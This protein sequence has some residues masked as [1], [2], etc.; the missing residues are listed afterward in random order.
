MKYLLLLLS[1]LMMPLPGHGGNSSSQK[2]KISKRSYVTRPKPILT[3]AF[4]GEKAK[5]LAKRRAGL[6]SDL[7]E[8]LTT[9]RDRKTKAELELRLANLYVEE[10]K[11]QAGT[12][13]A[14]KAYLSKA[15]GLLSGIITEYPS[16][17]RLDEAQFQLAQA[18]IEFG[19][20]EKA[21]SLF[22]A[23]VTRNPSSPFAQE[24]FLQLADD[25]FSKNKFDLAIKYFKSL[26]SRETS[27]LAAYAHYKLA[28]ANY[29]LGLITPSIIHFKSVINED[30][31][32]TPSTHSIAL[33]KEAV[34]DLCLPLGEA[35]QY[36][37]GLEFYQ[38]QGEA[39]FKTGVECL[40][41]VASEKGDFEA[42]INLYTQL[43][44]TD[45]QSASNPKYSLAISE[46]YRKTNQPK[47]LQSFLTKTIDFYLG[48]SSWNEIHSHSPS[49]INETKSSFEE[50]VRKTAIDTHAVA[51]KTK[52]NELYSEA[53]LFYELYIKYFGLTSQAA[54]MQFHL[55]E[56]LFK[57]NRY[58]E[59]A[60]AYHQAF[61]KAL[62]DS[63]VKRTALEYAILSRLQELN[64][65]RKDSGLL[66]ISPANHSKHKANQ[67][68]ERTSSFTD[69]E[70][71]FIA[72]CELFL[73]QYPNDPK[74]P[75]ILFKAAYLKYLQS[76]HKSAY[77]DFWLLVQKHPKDKTALYG[78]S[79]LLDIL[80]QRQDLAGLIKASQR[81]LATRELSDPSFRKEVSDVLRKAEL[82]NISTLEKQ[83]KFDEAAEAYQ[84]FATHYG[85]QDPQLHESALFNASI[86]YSKGKKWDSALRAQERFLKLFPQ[87]KLRS[88]LILQVAKSYEAQA[89]FGQAA[90][91]FLT[92][93]NENP[94]H[95][96]SQEALRLA[97]LYFWGAGQNEKAERSFL[98]HL[99]SF[100]QSF[101]TTEKDLLDFYSHEGKK[102]ELRRYLMNARSKKG[103]TPNRYLDYT[104]QLINL[105]DGS[106]AEEPLWKQAEQVVSQSEKSLLKTL[107]GSQILGKTLLYQADRLNKQYQALSLQVSQAQLEKT[108][109]K[110]LALTKELER[111]YSQIAALGGDVGL[112]ALYHTSKTYHQLAQ[113]IQ[114]A[115][116]PTDLTSEQLDI[117]R[118]ELKKQMI[119][120]FREKALA[121]ST[122]CTDKAEE[123]SLISPWMAR[124]FDLSSQMA[125][126]RF[127]NLPTFSLSPFY[128]ANLNS[129]FE[130]EGSEFS[131]YFSPLL[132]SERHRERAFFFSDLTTKKIS[133]QPLLSERDKIF[134]KQLRMNPKTPTDYFKYLSTLRLFNPEEAITET[135]KYL[136]KDQ[137]DPAFHNILALAYL[138]T[139]QLEKAKITWLS[140]LARGFS[141]PALFNNL[142]V[143]E[144]IR[145]N[146]ED[147]LA[148]WKKAELEN[149]PES[150]INQG[151]VALIHRNGSLAKNLFEKAQELRSD[152]LAEIGKR[153]AH[154]Q[155]NPNDDSKASF[156]QL[157]SKYRGNPLFEAQQASL[158]S[159]VRIIASESNALPE[160]E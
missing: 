49:L 57:Q 17:E 55:A 97:G 90:N 160:L 152:S 75:E 145:G 142:G 16:F 122:Q 33:K 46:I 78:G 124:C 135:K 84:N 98:R 101:E 87:S 118:S 79:L 1:C 125:P 6:I 2:I 15:K 19:D 37:S 32:S 72:L 29:N 80:N 102:E 39:S 120:P 5:L 56:I 9:S 140:L 65:T 81:L 127:N 8:A 88:E 36:E 3:D 43:L 141:D 54:Q 42:A 44:K 146:E 123:L 31:D 138:E 12:G 143:L 92:F 4:Q 96:Q 116:I 77:Q 59:A 70:K 115:P 107:Q 154:L 61:E 86:C 133:L 134:T 111:K 47:K 34:Q 64:K 119:L 159:P 18:H 30:L 48:S 156:S 117:Y 151:F 41:A 24:C 63:K 93:F 126:D 45:S 67:F 40:A 83:E 13:G 26:L 139:N 114:E 66:A 131:F 51:Q 69:A 104:L 150:L 155:I 100:P 148:F 73:Q 158:D 68:E 136:R 99:T 76:D 20:Q 149:S 71:H 21:N 58:Q 94:S 27:P 28:W 85:S 109:A 89:D 22:L 35:K 153:I 91:Y 10:F 106:S 11:F 147:A 25:A 62:P 108:L 110:K 7:K 74:A 14:V 144:A 130:K 128:V 121:F 50:L 103:I 53:A 129:S 23:I 82:K 60:E 112:S 157:A 105:N 113:E 132:F 38:E 52:N 137:S 95:P